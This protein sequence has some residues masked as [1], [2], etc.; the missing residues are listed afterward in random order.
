MELFYRDRLGCEYPWVDLD[1]GIYEVRKINRGMQMS[2]SRAS[3][4]PEAITLAQ[5]S[6][7][8]QLISEKLS[9]RMFDPVNAKNVPISVS[10]I[11]EVIDSVIKIGVTNCHNH[12][13]DT[14]HS[15][16]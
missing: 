8:K 10:S 3:D 14:E 9:Y 2:F 1:E 13:I 16:Y 11:F 15:M 6:I 12:A 7:Y 4:L 5:F